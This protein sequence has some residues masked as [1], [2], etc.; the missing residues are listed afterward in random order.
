L[1]SLN[2]AGIL[3]EFGDSREIS[4]VQCSDI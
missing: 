4:D 3:L 1:N 2:T